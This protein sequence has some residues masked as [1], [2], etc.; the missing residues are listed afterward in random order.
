[1]VHLAKIILYPIKS[2]DGVSVEQ[3]TVLPSGAL[4]GDREFAL[5]DE[6]GKFVNGKRT[7]AIHQIRAQFNLG[8]RTVSLQVQNQS[9]QSTFH[10][11]QER[12]AIAEWFTGYFGF[13]VKLVQNTTM[14]F[15]D[16][17]AS[18]GP[19]LITTETLQEL[20]TWF[21]ECSEENLRQRFR[22]TLEVAGAE[23]FWEDQLFA[24]E[25]QLELFQIGRV[26]FAGVNPCQRCI[27]PTR[28]PASGEIFS[29]F[30][31]VFIAKRKATLPVW[32]D[33]S[34]FN[35]FYRLAVNT[36]VAPSLSHTLLQVGDPVLLSPNPNQ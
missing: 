26:A 32:A 8:E 17:T 22:T 25:G 5:V 1:M 10:L 28:D 35:H 16:D 21:P 33:A 18:P 29:N 23:P 4:Q 36:V 9:Q 11:D 24:T 12:P 7:A 34:R 20:I 13:P 31:K 19:T 6:Q 15:P 2:L 27:V 30:Q 14:G 3:A